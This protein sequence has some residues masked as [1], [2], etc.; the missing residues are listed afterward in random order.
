MAEENE[1]VKENE[2]STQ[3]ST[4]PETKERGSSENL[5]VLEILR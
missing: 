4:E 2:E 3:A 1:A 5:R